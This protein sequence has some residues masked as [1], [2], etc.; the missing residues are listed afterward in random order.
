[1]NKGTTAA[2]AGKH[3]NHWKIPHNA[4]VLNVR[5]MLDC[6][7]TFTTRQFRLTL[8]L[9]F[10]YHVPEM[11]VKLGSEIR[12]WCWIHTHHC[13][14]AVWLSVGALLGSFFPPQWVQ[15]DTR[16]QFFHSVVELNQPDFIKCS[17]FAQGRSV[18]ETQKEMNLSL[19]LWVLETYQ[20]LCP[21]SFSMMCL[22]VTWERYR[23]SCIPAAMELMKCVRW[24][25]CKLK[26]GQSYE[27][28]QYSFF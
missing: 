25:H 28:V 9:L 6:H 5:E 12:P 18:I 11:F 20:P 13:A 1:M 7:S 8:N 15:R 23:K 10:L 26:L 17:D 24:L 21:C 2:S 27:A 14:A 22:S 16:L 19:L 3:F 4:K